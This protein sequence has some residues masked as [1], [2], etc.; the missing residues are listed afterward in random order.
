M[1]L[2]VFSNA[3]AGTGIR[4]LRY[5]GRVRHL[6]VTDLWIQD[7][8]RTKDLEPLK[9]GCADTV[10]DRMAKHV[11]KELLER[12]MSKMVLRVEEGRPETAARIS[13]HLVACEL[14]EIYEPRDPQQLLHLIDHLATISS[15]SCSHPYFP[16]VA[17]ASGPSCNTLTTLSMTAKVNEE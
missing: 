14:S 9:V 4:K 2:T 10:A 6:A 5:S 3:A 11:P 13:G 15:V 12:R 17:G 1:D 7:R 16:E 8:L